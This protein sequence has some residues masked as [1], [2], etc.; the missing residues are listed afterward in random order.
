MKVKK[1]LSIILSIFMLLSTIQGFSITAQAA[2]SKDYPDFEY[3]LVDYDNN[4]KITKY[5]GNE[6]KLVIPSKLDG[7]LVI[8]IENSAFAECYNLE[9]ITIPSSV[10]HIGSGVFYECNSLKYINYTGTRK[11]WNSIE[12][13][14]SDM[15]E[16]NEMEIHC[17]DG[18]INEKKQDG[19]YEYV[20]TVDDT[21]ELTKYTGK[22][23]DVEIPSKIDGK[24]VTN[25]RRYTFKSCDS[26]E[27]ITM[28][29]S[30]TYID[31]NVF[32]D[33]DSLEYITF[34]GTKKQWT[35]GKRYDVNLSEIEIRCND[36]I[37]NEKKE[38]DSY[39]YII[40]IDDTIQIN[41]YI[42]KDT[43]VKIPSELDG[44]SVTRIR[45]FAFEGCTNIKSV[46]IPDSV[47]YLETASF[48]DCENLET[49]KLSN[50][51]TSL[52]MYVFYGCTN[53][54]EITIPVSVGIIGMDPF[55]QCTSL[56]YVNYSGTK[57]Q[58]KS[59]EI[60]GDDGSLTLMEIRCSDGTINKNNQTDSYKYVLLEDG[61]VK[62]TRYIGSPVNIKIPSEL[63]GKP[64]K[65]I[66]DFAFEDCDT[67]QTISIP[68]SVTDIGYAVF[69]DCTRLAY[70]NY[71]GTRA[72]WKA[73]VRYDDN[74]GELEVH[75]SDGN[76]NEKKR[77][78]SYEYTIKEDDTVEIT[79]WV[80]KP[81]D[82][83]I[84][85]ELSG[86]PVRSIAPFAFAS[87]NSLK[88]ITIPS[89]LKSIGYAA[90]WHSENITSVNY[91]G[92]KSQWDEIDIDGDNDNL[93]N[94]KIQCSDG[95][96]NEQKQND[97]YKYT[98]KAGDVVE[99]TKYIGEVA[100][101]EIP[102]ELEG[103]TVT[104]IERY[105]FEDCNSLKTVSIPDGVTSID[106]MT[107]KNCE[108]LQSVKLPNRLKSIAAKAFYE[109]TNLKEITIP[110]SVTYIGDNVFENC[111]SLSYIT[112]MGTMAE[113]KDIEIGED[114]AS[115]GKVDIRCTD[116]VI[117]KKECEHIW[118]EGEV[119][120]KATCTEDGE[121]TYTCT[122]CGKTKTEIIEAKG[123]S[124]DDGK[125]TRKATCTKDGEITYTCMECEATAT[126][127]IEAKGHNFGN[128][129]PK[130]SVCG[131]ANPNYKEEVVV[132]KPA[133]TTLKSVKAGNKSIK[134]TWTKVSKVDGYQIQ[135]TTDS[136]FKKSV[137]TVTVKNQ[138]I[139]SYTISGLKAN[140]KY[141]VRVCT[142]KTQKDN[143]K[144]T[145]KWSKVK[146]ATTPVQ[147]PKATTL[148]S[149]KAGKK[150]IEVTWK[151][152]TKVN[153][154]QILLA[155]NSKFTKNKKTITISKQS[156]VS[157]N[158]TSLKAKTKY[159]VKVRTYD[160]QIVKGK[161]TKVY[162][163]WSKVKDVK[164]K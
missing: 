121:I 132:T 17:K 102:S 92:T 126:D 6:K 131:T 69:R 23:V 88:S 61:T 150:S 59:I 31:Y 94:A 114:D 77:T 11:Q 24:S 48:R 160:V 3:E 50:N 14:D 82:V 118:D 89:S 136:K 120:S 149:V 68:E 4:I 13:D 108:N 153:G 55:G 99:I 12:I 76:L 65:S 52:S 93:T 9:E 57:A 78:D 42:G 70:I 138:K 112:Y 145:S 5:N 85:S 81:V 53:L 33:C 100:D 28:P 66:K 16:V 21:I 115:L 40:K 130:C 41:K 163:A 123:H 43:D 35:L 146:N 116:G 22:A 47:K 45:R 46:S 129:L 51:L 63:D 74:L 34:K 96:I 30:V 25:I 49:V 15:N 111:D 56:A 122:R 7:N 124:F 67:L 156:T 97:D 113:W 91:D 62:I 27:S 39:K 134:V 83:K 159:Y 64:V 44:K 75:C 105:A 87:C 127:I 119:T 157:K 147:K 2:T 103:K 29:S 1:V 32:R 10:T 37:I 125:V 107:F 137:K 58:W 98:I 95:I 72:E 80:G 38:N 73:L 155:T 161:N 148:K 162:S 90:F 158:V 104:S 143:S 117:S 139:T 142:Y 60:T 133:A 109:C 110:T 135:Y 140:Q 71:G 154:Y 152:T 26:I 36:G 20:V 79:K 164:T 106:Y 151:K 128:N 86:K 8:N 18:N 144:L 101:V 19:D 84:E 54:R 141:Y